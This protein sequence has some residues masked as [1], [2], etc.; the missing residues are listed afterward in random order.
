MSECINNCRLCK[1]LVISQDVTFADNTL[2]INLPDTTT[3]GNCEKKCI[4]IAQSIPTTATIGSPV[5]FTIGTNTATFP[6]LNKDCTPVYAQ[7]LRSR[8]LYPTR[9]NTAISTGVF[10]Y[11][12]KCNLPCVEVTVLNSLPT[13]PTTPPATT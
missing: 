7:Q 3:Y 4:V 12:G 13:T 2:T 5:V 6:F 8:K 11:I 10:K 9:V 1:N